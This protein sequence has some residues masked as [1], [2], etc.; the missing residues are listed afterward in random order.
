M[1][2]LLLGLDVGTTAT[3][4]LLFDLA[5][6]IV[7][8]ASR[9]YGLIMPQEGWVE[10]DPEE[11]WR[12]VVETLR[13]LRQQIG[14]EDRIVALSQSSQA[15]TTIPIDAGGRPTYNAISWMDQRGVEQAR[16]VRE[17]WGAEFIYRT[18]GWPLMNG[19]PL[20]HIAWLRDNRPAEFAAS[21]HICFVNDFITYRLTGQFCMNPS[22]AGITQ[23]MN[24][25][26]GDWDDRLLATAGVSRAQMSPMR[27]CGAAIGPL[28]PAAAEATGLPRD[29][30]VVNGAHDQFCALTG[31]GV[32][33]PGM[34]MLSCGTAWV[35]L[36]IPESLEAG[37]Q[38]GM[39]I[40]CH[41]VAGRYGAVRSMGGIGPSLEWLL[42]QIWGGGE[43]P[44]KREELYAAI[45]ASAASSEPGARGLLFFPLAGGHAGSYGPSRGGFLGLSLSHTRGDLARAVMEGI[46][47]ELR[48]TLDEVQQAG[49]EVR[50]LKMVG[51]A[52]RS[53]LWPQI[54][55]DITGVPVAL[56]AIT[57]AAGY[58]AAIL[59]GVGAGLFAGPEA[60]REAFRGTEA[61]L[62]PEAANGRRYDE[63]FATYQELSRAIRKGLTRL[64]K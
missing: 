15:G 22:D 12:A 42:E 54:V 19:L 55:A 45:N 59:A 63:L 48:W 43:A 9:N 44:E 40:S 21:R 31:A 37:L 50:E 52:T 18:T 57:Q 20:E 34:V 36:V 17:Q 49:V 24:P 62:E 27:P 13:A 25:A 30:L 58:G 32:T 51:G 1:R 38:S 28:T 4:A 29:V 5:G 3:K 41:A 26:T 53:P 47:F 8:S 23:L 60:G 6:T 35:I 33:R 10:Q 56:P 11:L 7:A 61:R 14:P 46:A 16:R 39:P 64:G 2:D